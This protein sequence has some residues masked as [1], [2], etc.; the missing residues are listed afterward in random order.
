MSWK[1]TKKLKETHLAPLAN[2]FGRSSSTST[3]K[4]DAAPAEDNAQ[5][6]AALF[7]KPKWHCCLRGSSLSSCCSS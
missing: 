7:S 3:I 1:L 4:P 2:S 5:T 6:P